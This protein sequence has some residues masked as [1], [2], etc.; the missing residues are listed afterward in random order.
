LFT[1]LEKQ[2]VKLTISDK[3][4]SQ[5]AQLGYTP[6]YGARPLNGVIRSYLRRPLSKKIISGDVREGSRIELDFD[7]KNELTWTTLAD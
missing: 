7:D 4:M 2:S 6:K 5:L 3:A 1:A